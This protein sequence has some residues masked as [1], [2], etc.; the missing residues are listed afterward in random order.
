VA[1]ELAGYTGVGRGVTADPGR[2]AAGARGTDSTSFGARVL[3]WDDLPRATR[4]AASLRD[5]PFAAG[6]EDLSNAAEKID[7]SFHQ[8]R[9]AWRAY[10]DR[11]VVVRVG[12]PLAQR[13]DGR[14]TPTGDWHHLDARV[15]VAATT[16][17]RTGGTVP[18]SVDRARE[19]PPRAGGDG[20][21]RDQRGAADVFG[22]LPPTVRSTVQQAVPSPS[23]WLGSLT[24]HS[25]GGVPTG[26]RLEMLRLSE[27]VAVVIRADRSIGSAVV[28]A[29]ADVSRALA[30][31]AWRVDQ[32][33]YR[34]EP[35]ATPTPIDSSRRFQ[36]GRR[37]A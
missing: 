14:M 25:R 15:H 26:H 31:A 37:R 34:F 2:A 20:V 7:G 16:P 3:T 21:P 28:P 33:V 22:Y 9:R 10:A 32:V 1:R 8:I 30:D 13:P 27:T 23:V 35:A 36:I 19:V 29:E 11:I 24:Q 4:Q 12:R 6:V 5:A 18:A 17:A